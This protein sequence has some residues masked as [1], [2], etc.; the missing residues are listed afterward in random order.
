ML[1]RSSLPAGRLIIELSE[2]A[3]VHRL[4]EAAPCLEQLLD[5]GCE[6]VLDDFGGGPGSLRCL[7][8][9]P[10]RRLKLEGSLV[11]DIEDSAINRAITAGVVQTASAL[12]YQVV[13]KRVETLADAD[14]LRLLG[15]ISAQGYAYDRPQPLEQLLAAASDGARSAAE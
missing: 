14:A 7:Q 8:A 2:S 15:V 10:V 4:N 5:I 12:D 1:Q 3:L 9:L 13:A 6:L 11:R